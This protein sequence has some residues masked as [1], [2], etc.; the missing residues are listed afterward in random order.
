MI[1]KNQRN[2]PKLKFINKLLGLP[3][4]DLKLLFSS[5]SLSF[6]HTVQIINISYV[7]TMNSDCFPQSLFVFKNY[8]QISV[9]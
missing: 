6:F 2:A 4:V 9:L 5:L 8:F 1:L 3:K 7:I